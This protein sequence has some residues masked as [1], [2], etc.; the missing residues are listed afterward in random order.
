MG[1]GGNGREW[2]AACV[3]SDAQTHKTVLWNYQLKHLRLNFCLA[4][5]AVKIVI[6]SKASIANSE[7]PEIK[8][9]VGQ[10]SWS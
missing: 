10:S 5:L 6:F 1:G 4:S 8:D 3:T 7:E 9:P 2:G